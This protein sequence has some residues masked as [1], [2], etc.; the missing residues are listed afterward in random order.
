MAKDRTTT[1]RTKRPPAITIED[2]E[3]EL[4][5]L[6]LDQAE[7]RIRS[8]KASDSLLIQFIRHS[9]TKAQLEK[10]KLEADVELAKA[11]AEA[12]RQEE[13][14]EE[15]YLKAIEALKRYSGQG[16]DTDYD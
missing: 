5:N 3:D 8:G 6:A 14:I 9:S 13:R 16:E 12:I 7:E 2:R 10:E 1:G 4:I 15:T 11:K